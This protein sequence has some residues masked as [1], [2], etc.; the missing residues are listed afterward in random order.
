[1]DGSPN[2]KNLTDLYF[3]SRM[4][5]HRKSKGSSFSHVNFKAKAE[6]NLRRNTPNPPSSKTPLMNDIKDTSET[7]NEEL[8]ISEVL[9]ESTG[10]DD[11]IIS[12][13]NIQSDKNLTVSE[14]LNVSTGNSDNELQ[15]PYCGDKFDNIIL[16]FN[17]HIYQEHKEKKKEYFR[18]LKRREI[19]S[20]LEKTAPTAV[21]YTHLTLPT[22]RIV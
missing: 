9:N 11:N 7:K 1:M 13:D 12:S 10:I 15:C 21:S 14:V 2:P 6:S 17:F 5:N 4:A 3:E 20:K 18:K 19:T 16:I 8:I 22:K